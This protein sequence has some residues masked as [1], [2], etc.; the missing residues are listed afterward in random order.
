M[1]NT[2][3]TCIIDND[4]KIKIPPTN[5]DSAWKDI[6]DAY[7]QEFMELFYSDLSKEI[8]WNLGYE[9]LDKELHAITTD[10]LIGNRLVDKLIKV[11]WITGEESWILIHL[12]I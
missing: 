12:E 4:P 2:N 3:I 1:E 6:L 5:S 8:N 11:Q 7:F 9:V 10:A